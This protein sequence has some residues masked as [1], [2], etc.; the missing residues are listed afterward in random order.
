MGLILAKGTPKNSKPPKSSY[1]SNFSVD[2]QWTWTNRFPYS[3][4]VGTS[5]Y[6]NLS[7]VVLSLI[8]DLT[9][10]VKR[11]HSILVLPSCWNLIKTALECPPPLAELV[12][13]IDF[14]GR[15]PPF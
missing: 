4:N 14:Y 6:L 1:F 11:F 8:C 15:I 7:K 5:A 12:N 3:L 10:F 9:S 13:T 2:P